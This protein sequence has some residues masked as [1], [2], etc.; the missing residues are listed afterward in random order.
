MISATRRLQFCAG[1]RVHFAPDNGV[2]RGDELA[3]GG[4]GVNGG[5]GQG[6]VTAGTAQAVLQADRLSA[7]YG[8]HLRR[9]EVAGRTVFLPE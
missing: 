9:V 5:I 2:Q 8:H 4:N 6:G 7:A 1:H 3:C